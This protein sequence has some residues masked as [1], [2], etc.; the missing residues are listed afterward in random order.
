[1]AVNH[2]QQT[3]MGKPLNDLTGF[4]FGALVVLGLGQKQRATNGAWWLCQC[5]CGAQ[6]NLAGSD[7]VQ[8]KIKSCGCQHRQRIGDAGRKHGLSK[9]RTYRIW[10]AIRNRCNRIHQDYSCRGITYDKRWDLFENFL[11]DMGLAPDDLSIDRIDVNGNYEK[12]NCRWA[13]REQQSNNTR[14]NI[15]I[16]WDGRRQTRSQWEKEFGMR[17][18]TLRSRLRAGWSMKRAMTP[19]PADEP[20]QPE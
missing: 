11:A 2:Y 4:R 19:L 18:T 20:A 16:E 3:T 1:M 5:D 12:S 10:Q 8:G 6:K 7:M 14:A 9:S 15:F 13:T 17:P